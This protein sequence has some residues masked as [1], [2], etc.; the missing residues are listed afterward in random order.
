MNKPRRKSDYRLEEIDG[1]LLL[2]HPGRTEILYC[3]PTASAIWHLCDGNWTAEE[4]I[5]LLRST[6][7]EAEETIAAE[8]EEALDLFLKHGAIEFV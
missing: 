5:S 4:I 7:P 3:N 6:Y 8:V 1:E 2:Y